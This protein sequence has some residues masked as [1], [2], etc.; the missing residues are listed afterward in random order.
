MSAGRQNQSRAVLS[1]VEKRHDDI[2]HIEQTIVEL[3]QLFMDMQMM[4]EQQGETLDHVQVNA[5]DTAVHIEEGN[6]QLRRAILLAKS[7]RTV[8]YPTTHTV[9]C[10]HIFYM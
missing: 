10:A 5:E 1:E 4:V 8:K 7:T 3:H 2:K 9:H 6:K